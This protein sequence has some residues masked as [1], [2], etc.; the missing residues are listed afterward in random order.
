MEEKIYKSD[1]AEIIYE[2]ENN[3]VT[4]TWKG[5]VTSE[6]YREVFGKVKDVI[7]EKRVA[8]FL[9]NTT[10][11]GPI[12]PQDRKW[13]ETEI[14]PITVKAGLQYSATIMSKDVFKKYYL[15]QIKNSSEKS[16]MSGFR[17]FDDLEE[18]RKWLLSTDIS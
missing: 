12:T 17:I 18:G 8:R 6:Q 11:E 14:V 2:K 5:F 1:Y 3:L 7:V 16:G 9:A 13:L 15:S 10:D 4:L